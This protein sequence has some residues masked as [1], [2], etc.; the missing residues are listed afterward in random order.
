MD[1]VSFYTVWDTQAD[2]SGITL[3]KRFSTTTGGKTI[4]IR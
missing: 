2:L 1:R 3:L 4:V